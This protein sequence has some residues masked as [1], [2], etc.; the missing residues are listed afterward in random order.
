MGGSYEEIM[1]RGEEKGREEATR[2]NAIRMKAD[3]L[4][5]ETI[6]KYTG[7]STEEIAR[8]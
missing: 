6:A 1:N 3:S 7:L 4:P 2:E 5:L 8:L